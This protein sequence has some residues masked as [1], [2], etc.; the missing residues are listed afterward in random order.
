M[1]PDHRR[2]ELVVVRPHEVDLDREAPI[3]VSTGIGL[4]SVSCSGHDASEA[5]VEPLSETLEETIEFE[6][7]TLP[8][9]WLDP[10][11]P[12]MSAGEPPQISGRLLVPPTDEPSPVAAL[13]AMSRTPAELRSV[14]PHFGEQADE[15]LE[16]HGYSADEIDAL[17]EAGALV[18]ERRKL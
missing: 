4:L 6:S 5:T 9:Q 13:V 2:P 14:P 8:G 15:I 11:M 16:E 17:A 7:R 1:D 10:S 18:R 12:P 3:E